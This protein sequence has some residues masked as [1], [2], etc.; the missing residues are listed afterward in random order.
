MGEVDL[1]LSDAQYLSHFPAWLYLS[2]LLSVKNENVCQQTEAFIV[3]VS[4]WGH[5]KEAHCAAQVSF[6]F[7][8]W[9]SCHFHN[10]HPRRASSKYTCDHLCAHGRVGVGKVWSGKSL[11]YLANGCATNNNKNLGLPSES[12]VTFLLLK[13]GLIQ[14]VGWTSQHICAVAQFERRP[15]SL[16]CDQMTQHF[17]SKMELD[18]LHILWILTQQ[19]YGL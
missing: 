10:Q 8:D 2:S 12:A 3:T 4:S 5:R 14:T 1:F 16:L 18:E 9:R 11:A 6:L 15:H 19:S 17:I 7:S 13:W